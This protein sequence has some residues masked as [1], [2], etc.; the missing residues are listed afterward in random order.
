MKK[1]LI[2]MAA[3]AATGAASAQSS[4]TLFGVA[5]AAVSHYS[6][7][8][9]FYN[10]TATPALP[11]ASMPSGSNRSQTVLSSGANSS[12]RVGFRGTGKTDWN[13]TPPA[14]PFDSTRWADLR[15]PQ[16]FF[17]QPSSMQF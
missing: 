1:S 3:I 7:K 6:V 16:P 14:T 12:S 13:F 10:N 4:V 5:D 8:S 17:A 15:A 9:A 2:A 11:P